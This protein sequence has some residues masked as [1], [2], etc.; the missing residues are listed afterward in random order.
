MYDVM[1]ADFFYR[2]WLLPQPDPLQRRGSCAS[3]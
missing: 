1:M 3:S 2:T